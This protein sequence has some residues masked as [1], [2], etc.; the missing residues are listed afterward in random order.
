MCGI[1]GILQLEQ[2]QHVNPE[3]ISDMTR[4]LLHRGPDDQ[5]QYIT[6]K[7]ALGFTRLSI[8]D[9]SGGQQPMFSQDGQVVM[10]CNGEIY[11]Y[12]ELRQQMSAKGYTFKTNCDVEV[13]L[14]LYQEYGADFLTRLNGQFAIA[15]YD[16]SKERLLLARDH[17]GIAPLFYTV[18]E[19]QLLFGSEIKAILA[20]PELKTQINPTGLDQILTFP[21]MVSPVTMFKGI[22]ALKPGHFLLADRASVQSHEYWDLD[23]PTTTQPIDEE[24]CIDQLEEQLQK[25]V[26]YRLNADVPVGFYLSGG[27]DSS[28][29]AAMIHQL[30]SGK[31][32]HSFSVNFDQKNID[33]RQFQQMMV[34]QVGSQHHEA[35]FSDIALEKA[36]KKAVWHAESPLKETYNVCSLALS[37]SVRQQGVKVVLTGEGADEIFGGYLGYRLDGQ[38]SDLFGEDLYDPEVMLENEL[39]SELWTDEQFI[40]EKNYLQFQETKTAL[41]HPD[42]R[43][44]FDDFNALKPGFVNRDK[45]LCR[46]AFQKRSYLDFKLRI[47]DHLVADHGDRVGYANSVEARYPFLDVNLIEWAARIPSGMKVKNLAEKYILKRCAERYVPR[48]IINREKFSFVAPGSAALMTQYPELMQDLLSYDRIKRQGYFDPDTVERLK[49]IYQQPGFNLNQ[50]FETDLLMVVITFSLFQEQ[51]SSAFGKP[52]LAVMG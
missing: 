15:L 32:R 2:D 46:D 21:G 43:N 25:A 1:T 20:H 31:Q 23:Y 18:H 5:D 11:N 34:Q 44:Q 36:L 3:I 17:V 29:I 41:Y 16:T 52:A 24:S 35:A 37:E 4:C 51:F 47:S 22:H 38:R 33:E 28:L 40:Y 7:V 50:T 10:I 26:E 48:E 27:L 30:D 39:R 42:L 6:E 8:I 49:T 12:K 9:L 19:G 45:L 14:P 13:I